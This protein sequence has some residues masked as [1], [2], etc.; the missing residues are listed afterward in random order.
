VKHS[1]QVD[2]L[3]SGA[4][5]RELILYSD[6]FPGTDMLSGIRIEHLIITCP[7]Y[8]LLRMVWKQHH[9]QLKKL[10]KK[11]KKGPPRRWRPK[12]PKDCPACRQA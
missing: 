5:L 8:A 10:W 2:K 7:V 1:T 12:S 6:L 4:K 9:R 11:V 3:P